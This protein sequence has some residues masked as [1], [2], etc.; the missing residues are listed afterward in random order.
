MY[1][2]SPFQPS[3]WQ[4]SAASMP[5]SPE[6]ERRMRQALL[7]ADMELRGCPNY[8]SAA[9]SGAIVAM[10][11]NFAASREIFGGFHEDRHLVRYAV[12]GGAIAA[13][14]E[15]LRCKFGKG[16]TGVGHAMLGAQQMMKQLPPDMINVPAPPSPVVTRG[17]FAGHLRPLY[18]AY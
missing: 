12:A 18:P 1:G 16:V 14:G 2:S 13:V 9:L 7:C 10:L 4:E 5:M 11:V 17:V 3:F 6:E 15:Y 8:V